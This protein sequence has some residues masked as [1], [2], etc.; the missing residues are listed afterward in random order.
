MR[1]SIWRRVYMRESTMVAVVD[2]DWRE[3]RLV[4]ECG[5]RKEVNV[6]ESTTKQERTMH[7]RSYL[8]SS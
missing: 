5:R 1:F 7:A 3:T 2:G 8:H 6:G 4:D